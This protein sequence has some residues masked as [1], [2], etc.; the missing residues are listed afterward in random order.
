[1]GYAAARA[2]IGQ[3]HDDRISSML[4]GAST[5]FME[6]WG[7]LKSMLA[8]FSSDSE[9][10]EIASS[11]ASAPSMARTAQH[12]RLDYVCA[13]RREVRK[14]YVSGNGDFCTDVTPFR[15]G[16]MS[17]HGALLFDDLM[18]SVMDYSEAQAKGASVA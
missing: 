2:K 14:Q 9:N 6:L 1:M 18:Y 4:G 16:A 7:D 10:G 15:H 5:W 17:A 11:Y 8:T 3:H 12:L 13:L